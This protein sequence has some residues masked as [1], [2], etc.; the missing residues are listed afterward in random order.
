MRLAFLTSSEWPTLTADDRL[1]AEAL[2]RDGAEVIPWN[3]EGSM[4]PG[5]DAVLV[6]SP[7]SYYRVRRKFE[8]WLADAEK[9]DFPFWN[10]LPL[11]R[12]NLDKRYLL[13]LDGKGV[14]V[15][16]TQVLGGSAESALV[17]IEKSPWDDIVV[18]PA[19]SA[20]AF[21]TLRLKRGEARAQA[22][23]LSDILSEG[24]LLVQPFVES[25]ASEG[26]LSLVYFNAPEG[27]VLS[28]GLRKRAKTGDFR[29]QEKFGGS[30]SL[31]RGGPEWE[32]AAIQVLEALAHPW[33]YARVDLVRFGAK[34]VLGEVE[35]FEPELFFRLEPRS[36]A[37]FSRCVRALCG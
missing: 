4:P 6:R 14:P 22:R 34:P 2:E 21:R 3:W 17:A 35:V 13:E 1:A 8:A 12:W 19:V 16:P 7:W 29:V 33:L 30:L 25:V 15:V 18:K 32:Q 37:L 27:P 26:E 9:S 24:H 10:P 11:I 5:L 28:H 23:L 31:D 36:P 20:G